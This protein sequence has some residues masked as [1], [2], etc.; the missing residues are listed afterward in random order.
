[1]RARA[2]HIGGQIEIVSRRGEGTRLELR[3]LA[4]ESL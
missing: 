1:M 2:A 4:E 3:W